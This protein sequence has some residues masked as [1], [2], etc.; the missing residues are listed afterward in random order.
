MKY[1]LL[2]LAALVIGLTP[3]RAAELTASGLATSLSES[4]EDGSSSA[5]LRMVTGGTTFQIRLKARRTAAKSEIVY[6]VLYPKDRKG[7]CILLTRAGGQAPSGNV[8]VPPSTMKT[9]G[10]RDLTGAVLGSALAY[11]DII[12]NFFRWKKQALVGK[13]T[14][15]RTD[16]VI[17]ESKPGSGDSSP[18]GSVKSWIDP[19]KMVPMRVEK[20]DGSGR[21]AVRID[22]KDV[23]KNDVGRN[24]PSKLTIRRAGGGVTE[25][26]GSNISHDITFADRDFTA[27]GFTDLRIPR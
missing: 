15:G 1:A 16:C 26:D 5:R 10:T 9:L 13:E 14:V 3:V 4:I 18:Y 12:E 23:A 22:T 27:P 8:F 21:L 25:I 19:D 17:L 2:P 11:Q 20:Y 24:T 7:E 6:Q